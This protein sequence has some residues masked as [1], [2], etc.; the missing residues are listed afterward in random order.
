MG[1]VAKIDAGWRMPLWIVTHR[2]V[3]WLRMRLWW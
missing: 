1:G 2:T 3:E